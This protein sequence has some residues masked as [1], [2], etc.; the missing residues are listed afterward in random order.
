MEKMI[1]SIHFRKPI[2][3]RTKKRM[4]WRNMMIRRKRMREGKVVGEG[5]ME[6]KQTRRKKWGKTT[7]KDDKEKLLNRLKRSTS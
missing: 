4:R 1:S 3:Q 6:G 2:A 5:E 7:S